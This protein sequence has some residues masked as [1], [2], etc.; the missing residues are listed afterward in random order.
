MNSAIKFII[1]T[2]TFFYVYSNYFFFVHEKL[3]LPS[4]HIIICCH[5]LHQN[6]RSGVLGTINQR[7]RH[8]PGSEMREAFFQKVAD[9]SRALIGEWFYLGI[10]V[11]QQLIRTRKFC[12]NFFYRKIFAI[13]ALHTHCLE[14]NIPCVC[15]T[16]FLNSWA[17]TRKNSYTFLKYNQLFVNVKAIRSRILLRAQ[18]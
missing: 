13:I 1:E 9:G 2:V 16:V 6:K 18:S 12:T 4:L 11:R 3:S 15:F 7:M 5:F 10:I 8:V 17:N 14:I